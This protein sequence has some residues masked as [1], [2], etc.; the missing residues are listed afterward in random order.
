MVHFLKY[1][2]LRKKIRDN[3]SERTPELNKLLKGLAVGD[4]PGWKKADIINET[5]KLNY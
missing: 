4:K 5:L 3:T 2:Q 1:N